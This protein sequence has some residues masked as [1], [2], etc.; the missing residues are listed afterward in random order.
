MGLYGQRSKLYGL[1][2]RYLSSLIRGGLSQRMGPH[3]LTR[4][5]LLIKRRV[6]QRLLRLI[7]FVWELIPQVIISFTRRL[8]LLQRLIIRLL[9]MR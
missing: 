4:L 8:H 2:M 3:L 9:F 5:Q 6:L 1:M 7:K